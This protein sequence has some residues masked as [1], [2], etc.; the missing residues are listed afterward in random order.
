MAPSHQPALQSAPRARRRSPRLVA[1]LSAAAV[2]LS[3]GLV[4]GGVLAPASA[5]TATG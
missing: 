2:A 1:V 3:G 4:A 5:V